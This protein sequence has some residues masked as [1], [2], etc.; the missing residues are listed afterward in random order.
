MKGDFIHLAFCLLVLVLGAG[1]EESLPHVLGVGI[2]VLLAAVQCLAARRGSLAATVVF[3]LAAGA[4][5][6]ALSALPLMT[7]ISYFLL[8]AVV[9]RRVESMRAV[10][11]WTYP[12]YQVWLAIWT[13]GLGGGVFNRLLLSLPIGLLTAMATGAAVTWLGGKAALDEQ[14]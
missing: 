3:A 6:D 12:G 1:L 11:L 10:A 9:V 7:S 4:M 14:G 13:S 2:P 5:E 8:V